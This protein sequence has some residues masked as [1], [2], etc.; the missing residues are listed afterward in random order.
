MKEF[1]VAQKSI[2]GGSQTVYRFH[3]GYGASVVNHSF[4]YG[5]ELAVIKFNS[6]D[7][8]DF[9]ITYDTPITSDVLG[10]LDE[11]SLKDALSQIKDFPSEM[12]LN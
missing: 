11:Q 3:N 12:V 5:T 1:I 2:H 10:H 8:D 4:S 6:V 7:N 9:S